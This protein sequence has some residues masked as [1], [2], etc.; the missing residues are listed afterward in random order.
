MM[1]E[2]FDR[3]DEAIEK[4][5][6]VRPTTFAYPCGQKYVGRGKDTRSCVP[7]VAERFLAGRGYMSECAN[8]PLW[9]DLAQLNA[10]P[11]DNTTAPPLIELIK[12]AVYDGSW[13]IFVGHEIGKPKA[14]LNS[15]AGTLRTVLA[16]LRQNRDDVWLDTIEQ[17]A[18]HISA[19]RTAAGG[20]ET[21]GQSM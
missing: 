10:S 7:L 15:M 20:D 13:L 14:R 12:K 18:K 3:A 5:L 16:Y 19:Y 9:C 11:C 1:S 21:E 4:A 6:G 17:I 8:D 2:E